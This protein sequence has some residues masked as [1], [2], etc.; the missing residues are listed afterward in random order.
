MMPHQHRRFYH[1]HHQWRGRPMT[2][3]SR[4]DRWP[5]AMAHH[6][7]LYHHH[8]LVT[9][10]A[11]NMTQPQHCMSIVSSAQ[12]T[13]LTRCLGFGMFVFFY[14]L[15]F[16][17]TNKFIFYVLTTVDQCPY[18]TTFTPTTTTQWHGRLA[19]WHNDDDCTITVISSAQMM[20]CLGFGMFFF[21]A[22]PF[23]LFY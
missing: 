20:H 6:H 11:R 15:L 9:W 19:T 22:F 7:H 13:H 5:N 1:H 21:V 23:L 14:F 16:Y 8:H 10:W 2:W 17:F 3:H 4:N 18:N 12:T